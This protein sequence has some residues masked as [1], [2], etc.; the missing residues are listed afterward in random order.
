MLS[1]AWT[2]ESADEERESFSGVETGHSLI[3]RRRKVR[4]SL[5]LVLNGWVYVISAA[6]A[7]W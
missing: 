4:Y 5:D 6:G 3:W 7:M 1:F 2:S